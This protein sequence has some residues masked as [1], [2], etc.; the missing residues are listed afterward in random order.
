MRMDTNVAEADDRSLSGFNYR[1]QTQR[2]FFKFA[3]G[4]GELSPADVRPHPPGRS[5]M[6]QTHQ[7]WIVIARY[8]P[9]KDGDR[10][11]RDST[12]VTYRSIRPRKLR[13]PEGQSASYGRG[14]C[15]F[16]WLPSSFCFSRFGIPN[17]LMVLWTLSRAELLAMN[18]AEHIRVV[19]QVPADELEHTLSHTYTY[20]HTY[21]H[22]Y[23]GRRCY[24]RSIDLRLPTKAFSSVFFFV[25]FL[26]SFTHWGWPTTEGGSR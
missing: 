10:S 22:T 21:I 23:T 1:R 7:P 2:S 4:D 18:S 14:L 20:M 17:N 13:E 8:E 12:L 9:C 6:S 25:F 3:I 16:C 5:E 11:S 19:L 26:L 24:H 15:S